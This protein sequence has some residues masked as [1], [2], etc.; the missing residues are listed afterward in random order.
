MQ[1][2]SPHDAVTHLG[3]Y[4]Y[5]TL[6]KA[7]IL[8]PQTNPC[9][10]LISHA[11]LPHPSCPPPP[12][13][14]PTPSALQSLQRRPL[15]STPSQATL[16][17]HHF[18]RL[19]DLKAIDM[20]NRRFRQDEAAQ[21]MSQEVFHSRRRHMVRSLQ[22]RS[23]DRINLER[24]CATP[25]Q[26][27]RRRGEQLGLAPAYDDSSLRGGLSSAPALE[28]SSS[29][30]QLENP[31]SG[32]MQGSSSIGSSMNLLRPSTSPFSSTWGGSS[33]MMR[34]S[35][36]MEKIAAPKDRSAPLFKGAAKAAD[37]M[38]SKHSIISPGWKYPSDFIGIDFSPEAARM[39]PPPAYSRLDRD[40]GGTKLFPLKGY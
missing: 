25:F 27:R 8:Q 11:S 22:S 3:R 34:L 4:I 15:P 24:R 21:E 38:G 9:L 1:C 33:S 30:S 18:K 19:G 6:C 32:L 13:P 26:T 2:L 36:N 35:Q 40:V 17:Y 37:L 16:Q 20:I 14:H 39:S 29:M 23:M 7:A 28:Q 12:A 31:H 5:T 10:A